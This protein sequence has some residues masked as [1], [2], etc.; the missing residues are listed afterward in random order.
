MKRP[1]DPSWYGLYP[2]DSSYDDVLF[3]RSRQVPKREGQGGL[4][5]AE[6]VP[7]EDAPD[8]VTHPAKM[9]LNLL[10]RI[11]QE[12]TERGWLK[13]GE[14]VVDPFGGRGST[15]A[16]WCAMHPENRAVTVELEPHF[17]AMQQ[18]VK[19]AAEKRIGRELRWTI[20]QGDSRRVDELLTEAGVGVTSPP[21]SNT[22]I[23][24]I[25]H[26]IGDAWAEN[27]QAAIPAENGN[28]RT[29]RYGFSEGQIGQCPDREPVAVLSPPYGN[30][31]IARAD[32]EK[33]K[34]LT[35]DPTSSLYGRNPDGAWFQ[36]MAAGYVNSEGNIDN[37]A[38][39][40]VLSPPYEAS[41]ASGDPTEK[42]GLFRDPKRANDR[43]LS[44]GYAA[45]VTSPPYGDVNPAKSGAGID[46]NWECYRA[47]GGGSSFEAYSQ[48]QARHSQHY[49]E[50]EGQIGRLPD[51]APL[52]GC[53]SP[54]YEAQSGGSGEASRAKQPDPGVADRCGYKT[55]SN[56]AEAGQIGAT[57]G[58][59][60]S[61]AVFQVY[62]AL[63]RAGVRYVCTVTKNP[64]RDGKLR[65]LDKLTARLL[66]QAGYRIVTWR[67]AWLWETEGQRDSREGQS[68]LDASLPAGMRPQG[69]L[70]FFKRLHLA[71]G[72]VAAQW[73]DI[74]LCELR[75]P[76]TERGRT[77]VT[78][79]PYGN[80]ST[81]GPLWQEGGECRRE[82]YGSTSGQIG[83]LPDAQPRHASPAPTRHAEALA[84]RLA[85]PDAA[86]A[87]SAALP[88]I[89][90]ASAVAVWS[91]LHARRHE[92]GPEERERFEAAGRAVDQLLGRER[93]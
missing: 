52:A 67:R 44:N 80:A 2:A 77:A 59:T 57:Q 60:Y 48:Q 1:C 91:D 32:V 43:T 50:A 72:A 92:L 23:M 71:K 55:D 11:L 17:V 84:P 83:A 49:G 90:P 35:Q 63:A 8:S 82:D 85:L 62:A 81:G 58:E 30:G 79:P 39:A 75:E 41:L 26:S 74:F 56:G 20:V 51:P 34:A 18:G 47:S 68:M 45:S 29:R 6:E 24:H 22:E 33:L 54:P 66:R 38:D 13:P 64:T 93:G 31:V 25:G 5:E 70:S 19:A 65:R 12:M 89:T 42:G 87:H 69:R 46:K 28:K 16:V 40:A 21:Y 78:S 36:A 61:D 73:E 27:G 7:A 76:G 10:R 53:L 15:A 88:P 37:C 4:F 86:Q 9:S 14:C 3:P